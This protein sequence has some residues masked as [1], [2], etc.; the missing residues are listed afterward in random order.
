MQSTDVWVGRVGDTSST[1]S[2]QRVLDVLIG[3]WITEGETIASAMTFSASDVYEWAPGGFFVLH[4]AH[5]RMGDAN[6][7]A[8]EV[9]AYDEQANRYRCWCFDNRG[10]TEQQELTV[11]GD[12][13][14]WTGSKTRCMARRSGDG[15][16]MEARHERMDNGQ[17]TPSMIATM[18]KVQ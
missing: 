11:V 9:I 5:G 16:S 1:R 15:R 4:T 6:M 2:H 3:K 8:I 17:W 14:T 18:T 13:L 12:T 7:G 10:N